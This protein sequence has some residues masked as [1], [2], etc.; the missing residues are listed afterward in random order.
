MTEKPQV[1]YEIF[2]N[3]DEEAYYPLGM[4]LSLDKA[5]AALDAL[6]EPS[7][8]GSD[9]EHEDYDQATF[10]V[11]ERT[12]GW[13]GHGKQVHMQRWAREYDEEKDEYKWVRQ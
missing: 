3:T 5:K 2:D 12:V 6:E 13:S 7:D 8:S 9:V 10:K 4:F 1:I 11:Y